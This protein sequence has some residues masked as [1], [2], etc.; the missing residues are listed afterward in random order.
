MFEIL[1]L[2][3]KTY[4]LHYNLL[5]WESSSSSYSYGTR[6]SPTR[7]G[8]WSNFGIAKEYLSFNSNCFQLPSMYYSSERAS[9]NVWLVDYYDFWN[10]CQDMEIFF[11]KNP[12]F[13]AKYLFKKLKKLG[14]YW[15]G[16]KNKT[17]ISFRNGTIGY[18]PFFPFLTIFHV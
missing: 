2:I 17:D 18:F 15:Y 14:W 6:Q 3:S 12:R 4:F 10:F 16:T 5:G 13:L 8:F 7:R 11:L 1:K 9:H